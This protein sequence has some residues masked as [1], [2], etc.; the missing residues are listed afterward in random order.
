MPANQKRA[1][2][3]KL[4]ITVPQVGIES[5]DLITIGNRVGLVESVD[6]VGRYAD[7]TLGIPEVAKDAPKKSSRKSKKE[8]PIE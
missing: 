1:K 4:V 2:K 6:R 7:L 5:G 3:G 8:E